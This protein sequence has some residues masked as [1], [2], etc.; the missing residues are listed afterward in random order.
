MI[1]TNVTEHDGLLVVERV[2]QCAP[3]AEVTTA[4][5][6]EGL[7]GSSEMRHAA[8]LPA[9]MVEAYC[10]DHGITFQEWLQNPEHIKAMLRDPALAAFRIW[11]G[12]V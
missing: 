6:N 2:Q 3:I 7:H 4:L 1:G 9:V 12:K 11:P 5:H 10:N 8:E